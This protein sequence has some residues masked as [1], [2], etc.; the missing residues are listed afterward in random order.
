MGLNNRQLKYA[1]N[2]VRVSKNYQGVVHFGLSKLSYHPLRTIVFFNKLRRLMIGRLKRIIKRK[3]IS[4]IFWVN[5]GKTIYLYKKGLNMRMGGGTGSL[6]SSRKVLTCGGTFIY[7]FAKR[8]GYSNLLLKQIATKFCAKVAIARS[9]FVGVNR[10][11]AGKTKLSRKARKLHFKANLKKKV[12]NTDASRHLTIKRIARK[13]NRRYAYRRG[14]KL[15]RS[16]YFTR[17]SK[18]LNNKR[19]R[20]W[21][22]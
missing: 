5:Y 6:F 15:K 22:R 21:L 12:I 1:F 13:L 3:K 7:Y 11:R 16:I 10:F 8:A 4:K 18:R 9:G 19:R 17:Y 14:L 20:R 2:T